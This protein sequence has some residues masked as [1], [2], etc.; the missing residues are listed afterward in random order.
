MT[1]TTK[2]LNLN[3]RIVARE[4]HP[5]NP[6]RIARG[7]SGYTTHDIARAPYVVAHISAPADAIGVHADG[8]GSEYLTV[9]L[10]DGR[11]GSVLLLELPE[12]APRG[13]TVLDIVVIM[14]GDGF[15]GSAELSVRP[16]EKSDGEWRLTGITYADSRGDLHSSAGFR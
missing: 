8:S 7:A 10:D 13:A 6:A 9:A 3:D 15:A 12:P 5:S 16:H 14:A 1:N 2:I 4:A 11:N